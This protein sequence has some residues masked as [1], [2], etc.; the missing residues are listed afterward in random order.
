[1]EKHRGQIQE[2]YDLVMTNGEAIGI[3]EVKYKAHTNDLDEL[4]CKMKQL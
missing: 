3:V 2:E 1:M 4:D